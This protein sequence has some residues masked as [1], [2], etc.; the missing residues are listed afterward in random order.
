MT[1]LNEYRIVLLLQ[2]S[3]DFDMD[4]VD[5]D[6]LVY[7]ITQEGE[8]ATLA[9][10]NVIGKSIYDID[11]DDLTVTFEIFVSSGCASADELAESVIWGF[12]HD[13]VVSAEFKHIEQASE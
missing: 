3:Q 2:M 7:S 6:E 1:I 4:E 10:T 9:N 5:A 11:R 12:E 8:P 13:D